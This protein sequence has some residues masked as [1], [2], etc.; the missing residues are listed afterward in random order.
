[1]K[2]PRDYAAADALS[3]GDAMIDDPGAQPSTERTHRSSWPGSWASLRDL[4]VFRAVVEQGGISSAG[5]SLGISQPAVSR[6]VSQI[7]EKSGRALFKRD[8]VQVVPTTE[9]LQLYEASA[10]VFSALSDIQDLRWLNDSEERL[11]IVTAPT[12]AHCWLPATVTAFR[13]SHPNVRVTI[14]IQSS[15]DVI[16]TV[17]TGAVDVGIAEVPQGDLG[18]IARA[19]RRSSLVV[20]VRPEHRW[21]AKSVIASAE[22][23]SEPMVALVQRNPLRAVLDRVL[24]RSGSPPNIVMETSDTITA[25]EYVSAGQGVAVINPFP[26]ILDKRFDLRFIPLDPVLEYETS[27]FTTANRPMRSVAKRFIEHLLETQPSSLPISERL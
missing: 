22:F 7:E 14:E 10:R 23:G 11:G 16:R 12:L 20:A 3:Y 9:A 8:G 21:A 24:W 19:F 5:R 4:E 2:S 25:M 27:I 6:T 1:M 15:M 26:V 13:A 18:V 17:A